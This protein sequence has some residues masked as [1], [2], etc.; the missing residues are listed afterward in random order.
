M[1]GKAEPTTPRKITPQV[2]RRLKERGEKITMLT[3]YDWLLAGLLDQAGVEVLL[4]GDSC[5]MV[6][7]GYDSTLPV[8]MEQILIHTAAVARGARRA[9]VVGDMP[10]LSYQVSDDEGMRNAGRLLKEAGADAVKLEGGERVAPLV[11][12][13]VAAGI[14]VVGHLGLTPQSIKAMGG[15]ALQARTAAEADRLL[16]EARCLEEAGIFC[17]ILEMVPADLAA[18]V[19]TELAVPVIGIGA[20]ADCDGQ[21]LVAQDMLGL[22]EAFKPKFVRR[23]ADLAARIREAAGDYVADVK[24]GDFPSAEESY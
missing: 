1:A 2:L 5:G 19:T 6:F 17:L 7:H 24:G 15:Y 11:T 13:M 9:M 21:V 16:G 8:T 12:R 14:P 3:A 10:F 22:F 4:V 18:R 20:G 23:Y